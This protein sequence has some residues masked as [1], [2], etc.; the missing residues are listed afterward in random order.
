MALRSEQ[1]SASPARACKAAMS[2]EGGFVRGARCLGGRVVISYTAVALAA[3]KRRDHNQSRM[4]A[5][6]GLL[7]SIQG[8]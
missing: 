2:R 4:Q 1:S 8:P 6:N 3:L 7:N 5:K